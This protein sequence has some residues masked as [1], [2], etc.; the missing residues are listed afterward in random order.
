M[1]DIETRIEEAKNSWYGLACS[2]CTISQ[3]TMALEVRHAR[4]LIYSSI[5][6]FVYSLED[7]IIVAHDS[8]KAKRPK[9]AQERNG[10]RRHE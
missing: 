3:K 4:I 6:L 8:Y 5:Y 1:Q 10:Q 9:T 7:L 2:C